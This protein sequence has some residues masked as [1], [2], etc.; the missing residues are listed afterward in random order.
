MI[1]LGIWL[2]GALLAFGVLL[3]RAREL[4]SFKRKQ[5][6]MIIIGTSLSWI[7]IFFELYRLHKELKEEENLFK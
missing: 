2:L 4:N 3:Q 5:T 6:G 1:I 7:T